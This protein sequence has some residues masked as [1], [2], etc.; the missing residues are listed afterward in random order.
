MSKGSEEAEEASPPPIKP[1]NVL[2][3]IFSEGGPMQTARFSL[4]ALAL[5]L[6]FILMTAVASLII[7]KIALPQSHPGAFAELMEWSGEVI[8]WVENRQP[9]TPMPEPG[10][11]LV[12]ALSFA[13]EVQLLL[14]WLYFAV[15]EAF[16]A[17][18]SLGKR[19]CRIRSVS[20]VT[21]AAPP[22]LAGIT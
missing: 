2:D 6:D 14:F 4:R 18:S 15:G 19:I 5:V 1:D 12:Q 22:M 13:N 21:L 8:E 11:E 10:R 20:T 16:F 17:G 9:D 7:W 3:S